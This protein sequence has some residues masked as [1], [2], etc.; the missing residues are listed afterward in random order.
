MASYKEEILEL[1]SLKVVFRLRIPLLNMSFRTSDTQKLSQ[2]WNVKVKSS[3][4][5]IACF[6][7]SRKNMAVGL[8]KMYRV[9]N[10]TRSTDNL[11]DSAKCILLDTFNTLDN[12]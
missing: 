1:F 12:S 10:F 2:L 6:E 5:E 7:I 3:H 11:D 4:V 8:G 9:A